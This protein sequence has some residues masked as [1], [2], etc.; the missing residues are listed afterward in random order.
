MDYLGYWSLKRKPFTGSGPGFRFFA[1][2]PQR[3]AIAGLHYLVSSQSQIALLVAA[4]R[5]GMTRLMQHVRTMRGLGDHA[6]EVIYTSHVANSVGAVEAAVCKALGLGSV[7]HN[8][9]PVIGRVLRASKDQGIGITWM[10]DRCDRATVS[11]A[12][13]FAETQKILTMV[14]GVNS[15]ESAPSVFGAPDH[16][17]LMI[18]LEPLS[19]ADSLGYLRHGLRHAGANASMISDDAAVRMH[20]FSGGKLADLAAIAESSLA[21]AARYRMNTIRPAVV[22]AITQHLSKRAA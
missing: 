14:L 3:E 8:P 10:I 15:Q 2:Q 21:L 4:P 18:H 12:R 1:G 20:E 11:K 16:G 22:E 6:T 19:L 7:P 17:E 13:R 5:C 9:G